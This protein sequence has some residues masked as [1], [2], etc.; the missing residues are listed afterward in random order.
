MAYFPNGTAGEVL[1][2]Q[3]AD[4][5]LGFGWNDP[6]Q[7]DLFSVDRWPRSCPVKLVQLQFN[8]EQCDNSKLRSA[9]NVL[10]DDDGVCQV[11]NELAE[12]RKHGEP[13]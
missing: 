8:Y 6:K 13:T 2:A 1:D 11:R 3:C 9:M 7:G 5:P 10:I 12:L 4:C